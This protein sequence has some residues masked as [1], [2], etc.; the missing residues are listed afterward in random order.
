MKITIRTIKCHINRQRLSPRR[1]PTRTSSSRSSAM[2]TIHTLTKSIPLPPFLSHNFSHIYPPTTTTYIITTSPLLFLHIVEVQ[3]HFKL[4]HYFASFVKLKFILLVTR[5]TVPKVT[6]NVVYT[7][8]L[9]YHRQ[10]HHHQT[11]NSTRTHL[12]LYT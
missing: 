11:V 1:Q 12:H 6:A 10:H 3:A 7:Y 9:L 4:K 5:F 2:A 8:I